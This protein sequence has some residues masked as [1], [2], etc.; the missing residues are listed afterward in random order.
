MVSIRAWPGVGEMAKPW[1]PAGGIE[2]IPPRI[3]FL[4][5]VVGRLDDHL[6]VVRV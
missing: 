2:T 3:P 6:D 5:S 1:G 4:L